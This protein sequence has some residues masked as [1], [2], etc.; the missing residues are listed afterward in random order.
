MLVRILKPFADMPVGYVREYMDRKAKVLIQQGIMEEVKNN[1]EVT[2]AETAT[3]NPVTE[4]KANVFQKAKR[5]Y[6]Y[7]NKN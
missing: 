7:K 5:K 3:A 2:K 6:G 4:T 1:L